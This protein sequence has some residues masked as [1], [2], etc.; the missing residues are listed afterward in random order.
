MSE[1][2]SYHTGQGKNGSPL[3]SGPVVARL[4]GTSYHYPYCAAHA[5]WVGSSGGAHTEPY[6]PGDRRGADHR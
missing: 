6:K 4:A 1:R 3:C 2:C 5:K